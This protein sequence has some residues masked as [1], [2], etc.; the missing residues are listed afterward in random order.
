MRTILAL[1]FTSGTPSISHISRKFRSGGFL[2]PLATLLLKSPIVSVNFI[3]VDPVCICPI[4]QP[5]SEAD[6]LLFGETP[7]LMTKLDYT[8]T[9]NAWHD[10]ADGRHLTAFVCPLVNQEPLPR[11][12]APPAAVQGSLLCNLTNDGVKQLILLVRPI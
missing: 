12:C 9:I 8:L 11:L 5:F 6:S 10:L 2:P 1:T 4:H 7:A 3:Y